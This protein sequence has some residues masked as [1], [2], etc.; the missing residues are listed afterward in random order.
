MIDSEG[1]HQAIYIVAGHRV[2]F[3]SEEGTNY[4]WRLRS[5]EIRT[6]FSRRSH[7]LSP[8]PSNFALLLD[9]SKSRTRLFSSSCVRMCGCGAEDLPWETC[10]SVDAG[11]S[12]EPE[13]DSPSSSSSESMVSSFGGT[14]AEIPSP[15]GTGRRAECIFGY[16]IVHFFFFVIPPEAGGA[17]QN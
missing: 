13:V 12:G 4:W 17:T 5:Q 1:I 7:C 8:D 15:C 10:G 3:L 11:G 9:S 14:G 2:I 6:F 16:T